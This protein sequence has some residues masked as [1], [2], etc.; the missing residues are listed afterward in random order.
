MSTLNNDTEVIAENWLSDM[1]GFCELESVGAVGAKLL[2]PN[3]KIQHGGIYGLS[4]KI[5][6]HLGH[7]KDDNSSVYFNTLQ[8]NREVLGVTG[9]CLLVKKEDYVGNG[10]LQKKNI[11]RTGFTDVDF[12]LKL[13]N[14]GKETYMY[15]AQS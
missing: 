12:C 13:Q 2:Y 5:A 11:F 7:M 9:A 1:V 10:G 15:Q 14:K 6:G 3:L 8:T 4:E